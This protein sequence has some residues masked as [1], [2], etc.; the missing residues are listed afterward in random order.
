MYYL[1]LT[2]SKRGDRESPVRKPR[3]RTA[4]KIQISSGCKKIIIVWRGALKLLPKK[5]RTR[6]VGKFIF[7]YADITAA[8]ELF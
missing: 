2:L 8:T 3:V 5:K 4:E 6:F 1:V 7:K